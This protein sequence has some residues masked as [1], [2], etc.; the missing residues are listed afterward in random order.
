MSKKFLK[1]IDLTAKQ[2]K[3]IKDLLRQHLPGVEAWAYGSRA[4]FSSRPNSDLDMVVFATPEQKG[5]VANLAE[6][7]EESDLPFRVDLFIWDEVPERFHKNIQR[8]RMVLQSGERNV[9][10][11]PS[12][13]KSASARNEWSE[14][15]LGSIINLIGG[16]TPKRG[17]PEYW[18]GSIP[19]LSVKDF[20]NGCRYVGDA[21]ESITELGLTESSTTLLEKDQLIISARGTV[22]VVAQLSKPMA[23]NQSCYGVSAKPEHTT[24]D[25]LFYLLKHSVA[26][27]Q[28]ITHGAVFD[29][30]TRDT[31]NRVMVKLPPLSEQRTIAHILGTLDDKIELN[32][33]MS[34]TLEA[35]AQALFKSW[36]I[37]FD[38]VR[39]K[40]EGRDTGLPEHIA[41][42]F[43]DRLVYSDLGL[44]PEGWEVCPLDRAADYLNGLACQKYPVQ[45]GEQGLPVIKIRE[46]RSG[47]C[48]QADWATTDVPE[49][50]L[51]RDGDILFSWSGTLLVKPWVGGEG[52]LNQHL[53]KVTSQEHPKW[54]YYFWTCHHLREFIGIAADKATTMGH[55]KRHHLSDAKVCVPDDRLMQLTN[56]Y[57]DPM[58]QNVI[59]NLVNNR[60]LAM[61]RDALLPRLLSGE[62]TCKSAF[63]HIQ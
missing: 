24:N 55:I 45:Q 22:G 18:G 20:N 4:K 27:L 25:F 42:L 57:L 21:K 56:S 41:D 10:D 31:F 58:L 19:W 62:M 26:G 2:R 47:V 30:I 29:T 38:P 37:D 5:Y 34:E 15:P 36:F 13:R 49:K 50:Y 40:A 51:V 53:F 17:R 59:G 39:A 1:N 46:L 12:A 44:T 28:Q 8:K 60:R 11:S 48:D 3:S 16:G 23:F 7:F 54:F 61:M 52:V 33:R 35:M 32:R 9:A 43:P 14:V 6:A 63:E